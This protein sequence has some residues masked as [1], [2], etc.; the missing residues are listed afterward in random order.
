MFDR[1]RHSR[2]KIGFVLLATEQTIEDDM[3]T[4]RPDGVG[5]HFARA[6]IEDSITVDTLSRHADDLARAAHSLLPDGSLDVICYGCTSGSLVIGEDRVAAELNKGAPK[7]RATSLIAAVIAALRAIAARRIAVATP[8][9]DEINVQEVRYLEKAGFDVANIQGLQLERDSD[10][11]RVR[12]DYLAEFAREADTADSDALFISCGALRSLEVVDR[13]EQQL[14][15]PVIC[16]NQA[17]MW[18][19]LR[20]AGIDDRIGGYGRLLRDH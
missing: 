11:I 18:H 17:M 4:L 16:S 10:M 19:V 3:F 9:L 14:G 20:L 5:I 15:K 1:G 12:P 13:L 7:A 6:W 8:Y 2:A